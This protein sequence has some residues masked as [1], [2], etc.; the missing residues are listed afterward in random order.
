VQQAEWS[1]ASWLLPQLRVQ[2]AA[3][4]F[5]TG[6]RSTNEWEYATAMWI[7]GGGR[8]LSTV[9]D[10]AEAHFDASSASTLFTEH[11]RDGRRLDD[12]PRYVDVLRTLWDLLSAPQAEALLD[13]IDLDVTPAPTRDDA[14]DLWCVF[15]ALV[16][17]AWSE[18]FLRLSQEEQAALL[19]H[20]P[21]GVLARLPR[22]AGNAMADLWLRL[23]QQPES[24]A[25]IPWDV[26]AAFALREHRLPARR[27]L[28]TQLAAAPPIDVLRLATQLSEL[29]IHRS[30]RQ[31]V[32]QRVVL[33]SRGR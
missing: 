30:A 28:L 31:R 2:A 32:G 21:T 33:G 4:I 29:Q 13:R 10:Y 18:H 7:L 17:A 6:G 20:V 22:A 16:P 9:L 14:R 19:P 24:E 12:P 5:I 1:G 23:A 27:R 25:D 11:L 3:Q 26:G 8:Q 15:G